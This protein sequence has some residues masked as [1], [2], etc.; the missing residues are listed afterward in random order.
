[1]FASVTVARVAPDRVDEIPQ[2]YEALLPVL[3]ASVGWRGI[4]VVVNR[5]TGSGHLLGL[6]DTE[7]D[8]LDIESSGAF[9]RILSDYPAGLLLEPPERSVGE[10]V[11][12]AVR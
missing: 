6:W 12:H 9:Q 10:L 7:A 5:S 3:R 2:L 11:F 1:M 4:Y 8:A